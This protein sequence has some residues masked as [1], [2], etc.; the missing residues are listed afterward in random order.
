MNNRRDLTNTVYF[1]SLI[2]ALGGGF[3]IGVVLNP[4]PV[5]VIIEK[6]IENKI[7]EKR[8][9]VEVVIEKKVNPMPNF[10]RHKG[11]DLDC[12][13]YGKYPLLLARS[14]WPSIVVDSSEESDRSYQVSLRLEREGLF[15]L[16]KH[17]LIVKIRC[18]LEL[19]QNEFELLTEL[20][21]TEEVEIMKI[22]AGNF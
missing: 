6:S 11:A 5:K 22:K 18:R 10:I 7:I 2:I 14:K 17:Y 3:L 1:F 15:N 12:D 4:K 9:P 21:N 19:S 8:I 16:S 13:A 20:I